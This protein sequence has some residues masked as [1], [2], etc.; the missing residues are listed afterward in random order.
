[1]KIAQIFV[2][3]SEKLNFI[4]IHGFMPN[5]HKKA[6]NNPRPSQNHLCDRTIKEFYKYLRRFIKTYRKS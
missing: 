3:F 5:S 2:A 1:M 6:L 4:C